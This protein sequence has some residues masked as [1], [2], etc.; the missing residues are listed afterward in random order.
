MATEGYGAPIAL[1]Q[2]DFSDIDPTLDSCC[3]R[4][5]ES[6]RRQDAILTA[7]RRHDRV[8]LAERRR[9]HVLSEVMT[10]AGGG[11]RCCYDGENDG[12]EYRALVE[13]RARLAKEAEIDVGDRNDNE[14]G[15][16]DGP[17]RS[18]ELPSSPAFPT[19]ADDSGGDSDSDDDSEFDY[20]LDD[21]LQGGASAAFEEERRAE[22]EYVAMEREAAIQH[23]FGAHRQM[24]PN[25]VL[26]AA[27]LGLEQ[28]GMVSTVAPAV[29]LHL[30][31]S[32]SD[33]CASLDLFL[34]SS[35]MA[36]T[37]RG[38]KFLR[39]GGR[40]TLLM[41]MD[42]ADQVLPR[43]RPD[44]DI[45]ALVAVKDGSVVAFIPGLEGLGSKS[46]GIIEPRAVE[47]WLD[48]AGVLLREPP[49]FE[50]VCRIRPEEM[51][52]LENMEQE[53]LAKA[54]LEEEYYDCGVQG[55]CKTFRHDHVGVENDKQDGLLVSQEEALGSTA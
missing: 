26:R 8:A 28:R 47:D 23:G 21:G 11:C 48:R 39:S 30:Y 16:E 31:D 36:G 35:A 18:F 53:R 9:K 32:D 50:D 45:P 49:A 2:Q 19:A 52:L 7:R 33:L 44:K 3:R 43:V 24:D 34:E 20:L 13:M 55:C 42:L 40:A 46:D 37:Y 10:F 12:G 17:S 41:D 22:M 14:G 1:A 5:V 29:V 54:K 51:M 4:E 15:G 27:G 6:N 25:R 38:T